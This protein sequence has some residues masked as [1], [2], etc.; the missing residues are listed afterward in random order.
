MVVLIVAIAPL[1]LA[2]CATLAPSED[3]PAVPPS[4][5]PAQ[6]AGLLHFLQ[7]HAGDLSQWGPIYGGGG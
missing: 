3:D 1:S 5:A 2:A 7:Q 4:Q 6:R